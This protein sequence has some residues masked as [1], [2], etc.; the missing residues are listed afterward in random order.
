MTQKPAS[1]LRL[2][3]VT[4]SQSTAI[5]AYRKAT[6]RDFPTMLFAVALL[7]EH[8]LSESQATQAIAVGY[9]VANY[10]EESE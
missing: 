10:G 9:R 2:R 8:G 5:E 3:V 4:A 1:Q 7:A 6:M